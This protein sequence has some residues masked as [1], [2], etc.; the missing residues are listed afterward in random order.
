MY[1]SNVGIYYTHIHKLRNNYFVSKCN[2][3]T[4]S[5]YQ[6]TTACL[7]AGLSQS[8]VI[9]GFCVAP[10]GE[11]AILLH[12]EVSDALPPSE[13]TD[14][15]VQRARSFEWISEYCAPLTLSSSFLQHTNRPQYFRQATF[16]A[17]FLCSCWK[18]VNSIVC[19]FLKLC[20]ILIFFT[21]KCNAVQYNT[22]T[23]C[24]L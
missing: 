21:S 11:R 15:Q 7:W 8:G 14:R 16:T 22:T 6:Y 4:I 20:T 2:I 24:D 9:L 12:E 5:Q 1:P 23:N 10:C 17:V 3:I 18:C 19:W 13:C